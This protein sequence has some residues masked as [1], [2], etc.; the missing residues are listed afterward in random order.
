MSNETYTCGMAGYTKLFSS[1]LASTI[2]REDDK[3]RIVWITLLAM[4]DKNG[5]AEGSIPG[6]ADL[7]RVSIDDCERALDALQKPDKYSRTSEHGGRRISPVDGGFRI[8][9]HGKYRE[10]MS[11]DERREYNRQKQREWRAGQKMSNGVNDNEGLLPLSAHTDSEASPKAEASLKQTPERKDDESEYSTG[12]NAF[13]K[14]YPKKKKKDEAFRAWKNRKC[15]KMLFEIM[16][17]LELAKQ[18]E[19]WRKEGGRFI[20]NPATWLNAGGWKDEYKVQLPTPVKAGTDDIHWREYLSSLGKAYHP[21]SE[22]K[23]WDL[24]DYAEWKKKNV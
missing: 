8:L 16:E 7:A 3:V 11:A 2:W 19:E 23:P 10:K 14:S 20:S 21:K 22:A 15:E 24:T 18:C 1:I 13:W 6:I 4:A 9:N 12:F 5:V 17:G